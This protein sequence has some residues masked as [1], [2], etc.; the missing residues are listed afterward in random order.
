MGKK[1][2]S[3]SYLSLQELSAKYRLPICESLV[4]PTEKIIQKVGYASI[5]LQVMGVLPQPDH[6]GYSLAV[7]NPKILNLNAFISL[8][9]SVFLAEQIKIEAIWKDY[10]ETGPACRQMQTKAN[11]PMQTEDELL[12]EYRIYTQSLRNDPKQRELGAMLLPVCNNLE[13]EKIIIHLP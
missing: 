5:Q 6:E 11:E 4:S 13:R 10:K 8:G 2:F 12:N 3:K 1:L 9:V 7:S